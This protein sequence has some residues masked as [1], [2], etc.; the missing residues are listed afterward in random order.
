METSDKGLKSKTHKEFLPCNSKKQTK[1]LDLKVDKGLKHF[2]RDREIA[3]IYIKRCLIHQ[4][5]RK[6]KSFP[7]S[8]AFHFIK[9]TFSSYNISPFSNYFKMLPNWTK[10]PILMTNLTVK[11][12]LKTPAFKLFREV[13][14]G[15]VFLWSLCHNFLICKRAMT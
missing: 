14:F 2:S 5:S 10:L 3:K 1:N 4:S 13:S 7:L 12:E 8:Y 6:Y 15:Q 11:S 9:Y